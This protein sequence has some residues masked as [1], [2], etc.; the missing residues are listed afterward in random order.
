MEE[1]WVDIKGKEGRYQISSLGRIKSLVRPGVREER[2][3]RP[4]HHK[5]GARQGYWQVTI[6]QKCRAYV[7]RLVAE[8]FIPNPENKPCINH[9]DGNGTNNSIE[10]LEWCT[11]AEN[12]RHAY[13]V[14]D[15]QPWNK[16]MLLDLTTGIFYDSLQ[17]A[18]AS[19]V[20]P[21][22]YAHFTV[23]LTEKFKNI[24][25]FQLI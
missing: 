7:H 9:I 10:N 2:I 1:I 19:K 15:K 13:D 22:K 11:Y 4:R 18:F 17:D 23:L 16:K 14:L 5:A 24:T 6:G 21:V 20:Q 3:L 25:D 8:A 12:T